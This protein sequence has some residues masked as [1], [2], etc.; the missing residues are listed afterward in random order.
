MS[1]RVGGGSARGLHQFR[2]RTNLHDFSAR[3]D[4][5]RDRKFDESANRDAY[6][7]GLGLAEAGRLHGDRVAPRRQLLS[8]VAALT[9]AGSGALHA[10]GNIGDGDR[11]VRHQTAPGILHGYMKVARGS[12]A[13]SESDGG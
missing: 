8:A 6:I 3:G 4:R 9:V 1:Y 11:G 7:F 5:E 12:S 13:L 10:F 2:L